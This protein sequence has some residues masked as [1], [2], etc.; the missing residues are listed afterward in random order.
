VVA[1]GGKFNRTDHTPT[2][3]LTQ[4]LNEAQVQRLVTP[5]EL[6]TL[7]TRYPG[8]RTSQLKPE[9]GAT[10][11][12]LEDDF[13][14]FLRRHKLPLPE[15]NQTITGHEVDAVYRQHRLNTTQPKRP[16]A[17]EQS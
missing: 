2:R 4:A 1:R 7:F 8:R 15:L 13:V 12:D 11:A 14:R 17:S 16:S 6:T 5:A 10:R 3:Q 9:R